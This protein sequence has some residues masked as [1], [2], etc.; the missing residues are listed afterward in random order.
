MIAAW[1]LQQDENPSFIWFYADLFII[2]DTCVQL[3]LAPHIFYF[4]CV[5]D[6]GVLWLMYVVFPSYCFTC[7]AAPRGWFG[8]MSFLCVCLC[9]CVCCFPLT[10]LYKA[11]RSIT[12][13]PDHAYTCMSYQTSSAVHHSIFWTLLFALTANFVARHHQSIVPSHHNILHHRQ[14]YHDLERTRDQ[15]E[16]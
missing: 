3:Y 14:H 12:A 9:V 6:C 10:S 13:P 5:W 2:N 15:R 7:N 1:R 16:I 8:W 11:N 4:F